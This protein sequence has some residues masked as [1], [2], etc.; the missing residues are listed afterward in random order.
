MLMSTVISTVEQL[1]K[2]L[3]ARQWKIA[4]AES[5]TGGIISA[6]I[7]DL[8]GSS[9][10]F[11]RGYI[12]YSNQAKIDDI[13]VPSEL[14]SK[15]GAVSQEV[16]SAMALGTLKT[17]G[18]NIALSVTGV[19]GPAGGSIE[20]PV[21]FVCFAWAWE[22]PQGPQCVSESV[23]LIEKAHIITTDTRGLVRKLAADHA[24]KKVIE[25]ISNQ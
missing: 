14:I 7:T 25:F 19:A 12:T 10:W 22:S 24:I 6:R 4:T 21:G 16:A 13:G 5:C 23:Q 3:L 15:Y 2:L 20:K 18:A 1:A 8:A 11:E 17:S 9:D